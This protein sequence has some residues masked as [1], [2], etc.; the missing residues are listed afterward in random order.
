[1]QDFLS[2]AYQMAYEALS[3]NAQFEACFWILFKNRC[4]TVLANKPHKRRQ[5]PD[6]DTKRETIKD[7][8]HSLDEISG[9]LGY[10]APRQREVIEIIA[11]A[12]DCL[13]ANTL[14]ERLGISRQAVEQRID[15]G[16]KAIHKLI[17][18]LN[19]PD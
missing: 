9:L 7:R 11:N 19:P 5:F 15:K 2:E 6:I 4:K 3:C 12:D 18:I 14:A 13:T 1:M 17:H 16:A 10:L 8:P